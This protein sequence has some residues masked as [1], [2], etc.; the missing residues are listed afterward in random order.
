MNTSLNF[1]TVCMAAVAFLVP[2]PASGQCFA[3]CFESLY[4]A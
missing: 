1:G 3:E 4:P 2:A